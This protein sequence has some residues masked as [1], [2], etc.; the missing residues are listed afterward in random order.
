[1]PSLPR[2]GIA[3]AALLFASSIIAGYW[4]ASYLEPGGNG[5]LREL[6]S[7]F[8][9]FFS[10]SP[11]ELML[12]ILVNN[13]VKA[14]LVVL[15]GFALCLFPLL[16]TIGNGLILGFVAYHTLRFKGLILT[17]ASLAPHGVLEIP[18]IILASGLGFEV[19]FEAWR[20]LFKRKSQLKS[21]LKLG[22][23]TYA[24]IILPV[25]ALAAAVEAFITPIIAFLLS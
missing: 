22:L 6:K 2:G 24:T 9:P 12:L 23:K 16:F 1:L 7:V 15:L 21:K 20:K 19:G 14:L 4:F 17:V 5:V 18:A 8:K 25:L 3:F 10:L 11:L 13:A